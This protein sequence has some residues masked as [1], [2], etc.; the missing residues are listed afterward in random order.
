LLSKYRQQYDKGEVKPEGVLEELIEAFI[1]IKDPTQRYVEWIHP[2]YRDLV[3]EQL[4]DGGSLKAEF[5]NRMHVAGIKL[6]LSD[7]GGAK[8]KLRFP[9]LTSGADW[10]IL[11]TRSLHVSHTC[12]IED[13]SALL[14]SVT[15]ALDSSIGQERAALQGVL[16]SICRVLRNRWDTDQVE[17]DA[18]IIDAYIAA[19]ERTSPMEPMP[20]LQTSWEASLQR[21]RAQLGDED[22]DFLFEPEALE[23]FMSV[24]KSIQSSEPRLLHRLNF[25]TCISCDIEMLLKRVDSE[26][27][28]DR[29]YLENEGYD[30]ETDASFGLASALD[31][32][33]TLASE[34][35]GLLKASSAKL[36]YHGNSCREKHFELKSKEEEDDDSQSPAAINLSA[37]R[38]FSIESVFLDL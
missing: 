12:G 26:L 3:I 32:L 14:T 23:E 34:F 33:L 20:P 37:K 19:T 35:G 30:S 5:M 18:S 7:A 22:L 9:L 15:E 29:S 24:I 1:R 11:N 21:L 28:A 27:D 10:E 8:G 13:S 6:A 16:K 25:P 36:T 4:R 31:R 38:P 17:L 2:S